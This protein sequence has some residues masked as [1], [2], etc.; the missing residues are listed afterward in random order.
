MSLSIFI[1][2]TFAQ[3]TTGAISGTVT[4]SSG[5]VLSGANVV[6]L[7]D[8]TGVSRTSVTDSA[9]HYSALSLSLGNYR[10]TATQSGF[11]T[12][13]RT[14]IQLTVGRE[15]VVDLT[16]AV[17][18]VTQTAV[19]TGEA[20][21]VETTSASLGSLVDDRAI[22]DLPLNGRS[23]DQ[24][25]ET[26]P[27]VTL[28]DAGPPTTSQPFTTGTAKRYSVGGQRPSGNLFLLDGT[29]IDD[30]GNG[31]PGG[32]AGTNL[33]VDTILEFKI[34]TS[35][36]NAE[37]GHS[38]GSIVTAVTRS[39]SNQL[40]GTA[41]EYIRNSDLD[42]RNFFDVLGN[43]PPQ[44]RRNQFGGVLGGPIKKDRTFFFMGYEGLRQVLGTTDTAVVPGPQ[45]RQGI[46]PTGT[47]TVNPVMAPFI[48]LFPLPNSRL[49][50]DGTGIF[51]SAPS[52]V[53]NEDNFMV[54]VDHQLNDKHA[55]FARYTW[56]NDGVTNPSAIPGF[57]Q[58]VASRRQYATLQANSI[59]SPTMLNNIRFAV[60]RTVQSFVA[61]VPSDAPSLV[62]DQ[63]F[64]A[65]GIG[66]GSLGTTGNTI[67]PLGLN[68]GD[69]PAAWWFNTIQTADDFTHNAGKHTLKF[70]VDVERSRENIER[71][72]A[73]RGD[74]AFA[75][76]TTF[77]TGTPSYTTQATPQGQIPYWG[78]RQTL[79]G[80]YFQ[81]DYRVTSRLTLNL[82]L[83]WEGI[84][85]PYDVKGQM[86]QLPNAATSTSTV[87]AN[88]FFTTGK[89]NWGPRFGLAWQLNS[90][91]K[92]VLRIGSGIYYNQLLAWVM[93]NAMRNPPF[94]GTFLGNNPPF[95][96]GYLI[97][98]TSLTNVGTGTIV[99]KTTS[100]FL[101]TP[102]DDQ[103]NVSLQQQL[104][105]NT[106]VQ[107]SYS[108]N[109]AMHQA[110]NYEADSAIPTTG[111]NGQT[112]YPVGDPRQ[113]P[114][115]NGV[116]LTTT[117]GK[118]EYNSAT[119][120]VRQRFS[121]GFQGQFS[122]TYGNAMALPTGTNS[123]ES[124]HSQ[125]VLLNPQNAMQ[126]W[127]LD[128]AN[129]R[130][131]AVFTFTY[132][133][134]FRVDS[135]AFGTIVNGWT[136]DGIGSFRSGQPFTAYLGASVSRNLA[137]QFA[138]RPNL[139][140]GFSPNPTSGVSAGCAGIAAGTS[141]GTATNWFD[142]CAFSVPAA[143]TYGNLGRNTLIGP[144]LSDVD[145]AVNKTFTLR[146][147]IKTTFR[148]E[149][150]NIMNHTNLGV[151][152]TTALTSSGAASPS[153]GLITYTA[154]TSRQLQFA[155]RIAF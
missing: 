85:N 3:E 43:S 79:V 10:V 80:V 53:T 119:A 1:G 66:P 29:N 111:A 147:R 78:V 106:I 47:V 142:P 117:N 127:S 103:Y 69:G 62:P 7:N 57:A 41:F 110:E 77:L 121:S 95:P 9:G 17:G 137:T 64:G 145:L 82:G 112:F 97:N 143:G 8:D 105:R 13:V 22:R 63:L 38:Y 94:F 12:Q 6:V 92:T 76:L 144:G 27:G 151:P 46:L 155:L 107:V 37:Y 88:E 123:T 109:K 67:T 75:S 114:A 23:Y 14:G 31:T 52:V 30:V 49:L 39:G 99:I 50:S 60:N 54:R 153:A 11:Q 138:E 28:F 19:V 141:L 146:E 55:I 104:F 100:P 70:G 125:Y 134:P 87:V 136:L 61:G 42:A 135:K 65:I 26:Q 128:D 45:A 32:A 15:S 33:G 56:D 35:A 149:M 98:P 140:P 36:A 34:F 91:G 48:N 44:F 73:G 16:M 84:T 122:Y 154:T 90:S 89:N 58:D 131:V 59:F 152:T 71:D 102:V 20:P 24:L 120:M 74:Y 133:L 126:D 51:L 25:A 148:F 96:N 2:V 72:T 132:Q 101:K 115:W 18:T 86:A 139:K 129:A 81:D 4:D 108:G 40:H 118:A 124:S 116:L 113:N 68:S 21:L 130:H 150:F 5:A 93:P 83:R